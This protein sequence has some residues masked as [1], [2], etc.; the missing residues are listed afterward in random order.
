MR[1]SGMVVYLLSSVSRRLYVG[2]TND[3]ARRLRQHR[4]GP[5]FGFTRR[6][7]ITT[8]VY[9]ESIAEPL[10]AITREKQIKGWTR[11]KKLALI[12]AYNPGWLDLGER[13]GLTRTPPD[14][15]L[16]SG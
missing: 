13:Y 9:V 1:Q 2:V 6:Y 8:L 7:G 3:L 5:T 10:T 12:E 15:S 16:R 14:P 11:V 4:H